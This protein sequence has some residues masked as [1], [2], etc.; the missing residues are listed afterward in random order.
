M[1]VINYINESLTSLPNS[2]L[3]PADTGG[4]GGGH[5][6]DATPPRENPKRGGEGQKKKKKTKKKKKKKKFQL[7]LNKNK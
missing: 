1:L 7:E 2:V 3:L 5:R 6:P 4:E